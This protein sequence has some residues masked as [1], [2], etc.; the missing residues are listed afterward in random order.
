MLLMLAFISG[1]KN[2]PKPITDGLSRPI[3]YDELGPTT[4]CSYDHDGY[5]RSCTYDAL[6]RPT[7]IVFRSI[8]TIYSIPPGNGFPVPF[9]CVDGDCKEALNPPSLKLN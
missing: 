2:H 6:S 4:V 5:V 1:T 9:L 7:T 3:T 8:P